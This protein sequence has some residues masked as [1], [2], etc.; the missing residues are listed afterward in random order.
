MLERVVRRV[1]DRVVRWF[2]KKGWI[3]ERSAEER[4]PARPLTTALDA[5]AEAALQHGMF[6]KLDE[7]G[8]ARRE[9]NDSRFQ[10]RRRGPLTAEL[11][12]FDV[13]AAVR[14]EADDDVG[15]EQLVRY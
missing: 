12:G 2:R 6:A 8:D 5:C 10:P 7:E 3:E 15:R 4:P 11:D 14:I 13:Q 9:N 1:R